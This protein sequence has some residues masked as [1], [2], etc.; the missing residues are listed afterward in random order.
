MKDK[1]NTSKTDLIVAVVLIIVSISVYA[2][3][4]TF[5]ES[6]R[7][8]GVPTF[9]RILTGLI[10]A[11]ACIQIL[12]TLYKKNNSKQKPFSIPRTT[13]KRIFISIGLI[14]KYITVITLLGFLLATFLFLLALVFTFGEK[15]LGTA[16]L[17][18]FSVT[19]A[20]YVIFSILARVPFPEG[21][22]ENLF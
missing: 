4:F 3:T 13:V 11:L 8:V 7:S 5:P 6:A 20:V 22:L 12:T 17:L 15:R 10:F 1:T 21:I 18:S 2:F 16:V 14:I 19:A 9:P